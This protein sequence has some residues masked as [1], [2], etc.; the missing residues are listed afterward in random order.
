[1]NRGGL[2]QSVSIGGLALRNRVVVAP[3][4]RTSALPDGRVGPL[5][6]DYYAAFARGGYG[7]V[8]TEGAYTDLA[9]S[10]GYRNQPGI[11]TERQAQS[12][13]EVVEA[14]HSA[15]ARIILQLMHA[16]ALSQHNPY[17]TETVA[18]SS[19]Q[20]K[21]EQMAL[22][23]GTGPYR[24][25][26][27][28]TEPEIAEVIAT[29]AQCARRAMEVGFDGVEIH[30]ANGYLLDQFLTSGTNRRNDRYGGNTVN[31]IRLTSEICREVRETVG[32][33]FTVG[34]RISQ[35]KVN[36]FVH[37][38]EQGE[39]DAEAVFSTLGNSGV[40]YLHTTEFEA[41]APAF[42][43]G[44]SLAALAKRYAGVPVIANGS[45]HQA[46]QAAS[47]LARGDADLIS[48]AR[49]ALANSDWPARL[50]DGLPFRAFEAAIIQPLATIE[51]AHRYFAS[52]SEEL[53][54]KEE[55]RVQERHTK[56]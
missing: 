49:G 54:S 9:H 56:T 7:L 46:T 23:D 11:A 24:L 30:G 28:I 3:M 15:D 25:P 53:A 12:W 51:N 33:G 41:A 39:K 10:Q 5:M 27:S 43:E 48:L 2:L 8:I 4:T 22:Y 20:P 17:A 16:G 37:K 32:S 1:M 38:W 18:P 6:R 13:R 44:L 29:F 55:V 40:D 35:G 34:V 50:R 52:I 36:D 42:G 19:V 26:R 31:R 45:L 14:V 47:F 21:G